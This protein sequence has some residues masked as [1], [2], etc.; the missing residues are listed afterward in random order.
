CTDAFSPQVEKKRIE[1]MSVPTR[2]TWSWGCLCR[3][4]AVLSLLAG[5]SLHADELPPAEVEGQP[6]AA[7]VGRLLQ[8]LDSLG[9]PLPEATR[10]ALQPA[11]AERDARKVQQLLD[12]HVL[13][14][15]TINPESRVKATQGPAKAVLQQAGFTPVLVKVVNDAGVTAPL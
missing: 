11:L 10:K 15:V 5:A 4:L 7:N 13:F 1:E 12:P 6:L 9:A 8:A 2:G 3:L 14:A